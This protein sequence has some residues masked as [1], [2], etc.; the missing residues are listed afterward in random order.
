[1]YARLITTEAA[2][3]LGLDEEATVALWNDHLAAIYQGADGFQGAY[4]LGNAGD[5]KG[6][7]ITLWD[8]EESADKSGTFEQT[9]THIRDSLALAPTIDGYDVIVHI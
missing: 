7:T 3:N 8:S 6:L 5:R 4:V 2:P 1:M 9:L